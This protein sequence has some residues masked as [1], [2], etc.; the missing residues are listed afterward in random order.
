MTIVWEGKLSNVEVE[1]H[2]LKALKDNY[3]YLVIWEK[4]AI[5]FDPGDPKPVIDFVNSENIE[6]TSIFLTHSHSDHVGGVKDLVSTFQ[7]NVVG[8][9]AVALPYVEQIASPDDELITGPFVIRVL[10]TP[11]HIKNHISYYFPEK[12]LLFSGDTIF[13]AGCGKVLD[14]THEELLNSLKAIAHL[15]KDT[16]IFFA[17]E[18]T[19]ANLA[20]AK[21]I[22]SSNTDIDARIQREEKKIS[23][24]IPT[25]PSTLEEE[26]KTNPFLRT[27][28]P[29]IKKMLHLEEGTDL[30]VF[31]K[32]RTLKDQFKVS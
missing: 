8:P 26:F 31:T 28:N 24:G 10:A 12:H 4:K 6:L 7:A 14:G 22:D 5:C 25:P 20:F 9:D 11:G 13:G 21:S 29:E 1:I 15:P 23:E 2:A 32:I 16:K 18:Y 27:K 17:H 3:I 19:L 30:E